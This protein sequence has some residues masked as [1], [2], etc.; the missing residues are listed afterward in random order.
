MPPAVQSALGPLAP[1]RL[2]RVDAH[3]HLFLSTPVLPGD[4]YDDLDR[5]AEEVAGVKA[6]GIG[7]IVELTPVGLGRDPRKLAEVARRTGVHVVAATGFHRDAH[8]PAGH[9]ALREPAEVL[10]EVLLQD[11]TVGMDGRDWQGPVPSP[12]EV[13]AGIVKLGASY[14]RLSPRER[15]RLEV[16]AEAARRTGVPVAVHCEVGTMAHE[17]L[18]LLQRGGVPPERVLLAHMDRNPDA[19]LHR[20]LADRGA[21][22]LYDQVGRVT[23]RPESQLVGLVA[24]LVESGHDARVLLGTDT[25]R[26]SMLRAYGGGPGMDVLGRAFLPRLERRVGAE[27]VDRIVRANPA[28][29]LP[30]VSS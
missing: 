29:V 1:D 9:W 11:L 4:D 17:L 30:A 6:S 24:G 25:A 28:R 20:E 8:Y 7:T 3:E 15:R 26:R 19:D 18:D 10:L 16:G 21:Y 5:V 14:Q 22:L 23:Y 27:A 13:R 12:T 2:G